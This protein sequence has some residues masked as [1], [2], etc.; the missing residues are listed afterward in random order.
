MENEENA[1]PRDEEKPAEWTVDPSGPPQP[2]EKADDL[3]PPPAC[4]G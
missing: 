3:T 4:A 2:V 1:L